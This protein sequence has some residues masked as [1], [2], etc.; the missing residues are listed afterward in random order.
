MHVTWQGA[1]NIENLYSR[2]R[3]RMRREE[4]NS[5]VLSC[6]VA[7]G[8][9]GCLNLSTILSEIFWLKDVVSLLRDKQ[10]LL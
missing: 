5:E 9:I 7:S 10:S 8:D 2:M 4:V 6:S 1:M 3:M